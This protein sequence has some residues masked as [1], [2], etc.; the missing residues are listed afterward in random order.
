MGSLR[1]FAQLEEFADTHGFPIDDQS[2]K[3]R[4]RP[5]YA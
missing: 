4:R 3:W 2:R 1:D 5:W